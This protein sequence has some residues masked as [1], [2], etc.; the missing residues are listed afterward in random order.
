MCC[1]YL[2]PFAHLANPSSSHLICLCSL[3]MAQTPIFFYM[4]TNG[5]F[6]FKIGLLNHQTPKNT[7]WNSH[8]SRVCFMDG[9]C[10]PWNTRDFRVTNV[11]DYVIIEISNIYFSQR[12]LFW[13]FVSITQFHFSSKRRSLIRESRS[14][15]EKYGKVPDSFSFIFGEGDQFTIHSANQLEWRVNFCRF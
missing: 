5:Q 13:F 11:I 3:W 14:L 12:F 15:Y 2:L 8:K 1:L 4:W 6:F 7:A 10:S 9:D